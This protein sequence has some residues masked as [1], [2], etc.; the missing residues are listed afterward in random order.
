ML[1]ALIYPHQ[2]FANHPA[3]AQADLCVLIEEPLLFTQYRF[4][5]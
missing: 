3:I 5:A 4:H 2:L 1:A